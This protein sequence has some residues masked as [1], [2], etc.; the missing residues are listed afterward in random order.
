MVR[1]KIPH[2]STVIS[3]MSDLLA[4]LILPSPP[5]PADTQKEAPSS[6][7]QAASQADNSLVV[8]DVEAYLN[9]P[10][11]KALMASSS[12]KPSTATAYGAPQPVQVGRPKTIHNVPALNHLCQVRNLVPQFEIEVQANGGFGGCLRIGTETVYSH[13]GF[14]SK[15]EAKEALAEKGVELVNSMVIKG[16]ET[17]KSS[18]EERKNW[19]GLLLGTSDTPRPISLAE[20]LQNTTTRPGLS[21]AGSGPISS[22]ISWVPPLPAPAPSPDMMVSSLAPKPHRSRIRK[23]HATKPRSKLWNFSSPRASRIPMARSRRRGPLL[24]RSSMRRG[25]R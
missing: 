16:K 8:H 3:T 22:S 9:D 23:P 6:D 2:I 4:S 21:V 18:E 11:N 15:K 7:H 10:K 17:G 13:E 14:P 19:V 1:P 5:R 24:E 20:H 12:K 25:R